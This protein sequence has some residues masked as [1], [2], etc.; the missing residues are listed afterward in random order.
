[1]DTGRLVCRT[2]PATRGAAPA[3]VAA[4]DGPIVQ[5]TEGRASPNRTYQDLL[6]SAHDERLF[7]HYFTSRLAI[8]SLDGAVRPVG[9]PA[10]WTRAVASPDGRYLYTEAVHRPYSYVVPFQRFPVRMAVLDAGTG[11]EVKLLHDRPL[12]ETRSMSFDATV[13]GPRDV[14]WRTDAPATLVWAHA[15]DD[16]DPA[17]KRATRDRLYSLAAPFGTDP[18]A[19]LDVEFRIDE[20]AW[21][22]AA[23]ADGRQLAI[24][25]ESWSR[26][27]RART[28]AFDPSRPG[29]APRLL[30][31][32]STEDRYGDPGKLVYARNA[33]NRYLLQTAD[34]GRSA[35]L[36]GTGASSEGDRP[37]L[38]KLDLLTGKTTRLFRSAAPHY[39]EP[40]ALLDSAGTRI[41]T[42]RQGVAEVP[43]YWARDLARR[44][45]PRRLTAFTDPAPQ[46][47]GA[48][49]ELVTYARADGVRLS[50]TLYLPPGYDRTRDG[51]LPFLLWAYPQEFRSR[52]AASQVVGS[53][54]LFTRPTGASHLFLL[55]QGYGVLDGPTMPIVAEGDGE[56]ND[57]YVEQLVA[58]ARAA[59]DR[60][61]ALGVADRERVAVGGHSYGA[62]M[63]ANLLAHSS[64]FRAG[65]ARSGAYN[66]TLTPFGFQGEERPYWAARA[67]YERMSPFTYA[68]SVK[69]P[70]LLVHGMA[71]DNSGTFPVQS[72]R[73][74]QALKGNG[75]TVRY[76]QLP[77][78]AHAY[79]ARESVGHTLFEM[80][81]WLDVHVKPKKSQPR[82]D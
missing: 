47:A 13:A 56:S 35:F 36:V 74:F 18:V 68:D 20:L 72:E 28:W 16:G 66:R 64:L 4:P 59:V 26:T 61:V 21:T 57:T 6:Q 19:H 31:E 69:T 70:I 44:I 67:L 22:G 41:L 75:A 12:Q 80:T 38:D 77:A 71:D 63:T 40:V 49:K 58:S 15:L 48:T 33:T 2:V 29:A 39:E 76:V 54:Y 32:R 8:V 11:R 82:V 5:E 34:G 51:P 24:V 17:V 43:N 62:F 23:G 60:I 53:P 10:L 25:G 65:I 78:E 9:A 27:K 52:D 79:R 46:F 55:T 73:F 1:M 3:E 81:R 42:R 14:A 7:E 45:A 37:F 50:A 30:W